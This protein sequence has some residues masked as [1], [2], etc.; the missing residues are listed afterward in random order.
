[1]IGIPKVVIQTDGSTALTLAGNNFFLNNISNGSGPELMY[2][3]VAVTV[4]EFDTFT[5][6]GAVQVAGDLAN[7]GKQSGNSPSL[8]VW[9]RR[10]HRRERWRTRCAPSKAAE[11]EASAATFLRNEPNRLCRVTSTPASL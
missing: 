2:K 6:I 9:G 5:P 3:G 4:G 8:G 7:S 1:V 10:V 11:A